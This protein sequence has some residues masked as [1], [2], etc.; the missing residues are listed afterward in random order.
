MDN[1]IAHLK[2]IKFYYKRTN[3][4]SFYELLVHVPIY[5]LLYDNTELIEQIKNDDLIIKMLEYYKP[6]KNIPH[7]KCFIKILIKHCINDGLRKE[8]LNKIIDCYPSLFNA[9]IIICGCY[10]ENIGI[11]SNES[12]IQILLYD[13]K[14][15]DKIYTEE[16]IYKIIDYF[17]DLY[18]LYNNDFIVTRI[19][20]LIHRAPYKLEIEDKIRSICNSQNNVLSL[21]CNYNPSNAI[22]NLTIL[23]NENITPPDPIHI[24]VDIEKEHIIKF[25]DLITYNIRISDIT[26]LLTIDTW[27]S[28]VEMGCLNNDHVNMLFQQLNRKP[29]TDYIILLIIEIYNHEFNISELSR[30]I[31]I[32]YILKNEE[33]QNCYVGTF[34]E[35]VFNNEIEINFIELFIQCVIDKYPDELMQIDLSSKYE[36]KNI[37]DHYVLL[38]TT[39]S[40]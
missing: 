9:L 2:T 17:L 30:N 25:M 24:S 36:I 40:A 28:I 34:I 14:N 37:V 29:K 27:Y 33:L 4:R 6:K 39:K 18:T 3:L 38:K 20:T 22:Y 1:L 8:I 5:K 16:D 11:E 12:Y 7:E 26:Q 19:N 31:Q 15:I 23:L 35:I 21:L 32:Y 13:T 10:H